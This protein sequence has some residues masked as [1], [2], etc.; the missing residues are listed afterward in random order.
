[1]SQYDFTPADHARHRAE[2]DK[3][4]AYRAKVRAAGVVIQARPEPAKPNV[5]TPDERLA[6]VLESVYAGLD[7]SPI[8]GNSIRCEIVRDD[9]RKHGREKTTVSVGQCRNIVRSYL[10]GYERFAGDEARRCK[11]MPGTLFVSLEDYLN[12]QYNDKFNAR[13]IIPDAAW[14]PLISEERARREE[15]A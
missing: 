5:L 10:G 2:M 8:S 3:I 6:K 4:S 14:G 13:V 9:D 7:E 15:R 1:M 11:K 12:A